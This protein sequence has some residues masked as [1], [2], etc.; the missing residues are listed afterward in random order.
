MMQSLGRKY[1]QYINLTYRRTGTLWE[2]RYKSTLV[3]GD[4]YF[5]TVSRHIELNPVRAKIVASPSA[6]QGSVS[7]LDPQQDPQQGFIILRIKII[8]MVQ[9][10]CSGC[11]DRAKIPGSFPI[12][13]W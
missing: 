10:Q 6:D 5:L 8:A 3:D 1:V 4:S 9:K 13:R 7:P 12:Q 2:G 11:S